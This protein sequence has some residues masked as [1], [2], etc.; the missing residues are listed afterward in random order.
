MTK[1]KVWP[2]KLTFNSSQIP[3]GD[4][5]SGSG[6][7]SQVECG[8]HSSTILS[9]EKRLALLEEDV[10]IMKQTAEEEKIRLENLRAVVKA[11]YDTSRRINDMGLARTEEGGKIIRCKAQNSIGLTSRVDTSK[12]DSLTKHQQSP[13]DSQVDSTVEY[14]S[15]DDSLSSTSN[16]STNE[17]HDYPLILQRMKQ[18]IVIRLANTFRASDL[19]ATAITMTGSES[20]IQ[21]T[22]SSEQEASSSLSSHSKISGSTNFKA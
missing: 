22:Q 13:Q 2:N 21:T 4:I 19:A 9:L 16:C 3:P 18:E 20:S 8:L 5:Y 12:F 14:F 6:T 1:S 15:E 11:R 10:R 7:K 17:S